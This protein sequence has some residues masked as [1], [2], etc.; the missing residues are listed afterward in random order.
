MFWAK[1]VQQVDGVP[2]AMVGPETHGAL[3]DLTPVD[4][5]AANSDA[6]DVWSA[7]LSLDVEPLKLQLRVHVDVDI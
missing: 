7:S 5:Q 6:H 4:L 3:R 1:G 2:E